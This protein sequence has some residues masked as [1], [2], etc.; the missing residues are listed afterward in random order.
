MVVELILHLTCL[1]PLAWL[2]GVVLG[3][4]LIAMWAAAALYILLLAAIMGWKF[5]EGSWKH[6]SI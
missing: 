5:A 6:I 2:F 1:V 3:G 4:G